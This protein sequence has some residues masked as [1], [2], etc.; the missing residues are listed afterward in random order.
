MKL[1][2]TFQH[3]VIDFLKSLPNMDDAKSRRAFI[4]SVGLDSQLQDQISFDE[5]PAQ[6]LPILVSTLL[7]YGKLEDGQ[8]ALEAVLQSAKDYIGQDRQ[9][10][11]ETLIKEFRAH[12]DKNQNQQEEIIIQPEANERNAQKITK[13]SNLA[14]SR[15]VFISYSYCD[16]D[17]TLKLATDLKNRGLQVWV[18]VLDGIAPGD[19]LG[20]SISRA[21]SKCGIFLPVI[22][23][24]YC[25]SRNCRQELNR[26]YE[27]EKS[28]IPVNI[29]RIPV[30][31]MPLQ[32]AGCSF[33][34]F[35]H[36]DDTASYTKLLNE[37]SSHLAKL[38][39]VNKLIPPDEQIRYLNNIIAEME[40][41]RGIIQYI[42]LASDIKHPWD[43]VD[44]WGYR[45][46]FSISGTLYIENIKGNQIV[47][48]ISEVIKEYGILL[49]LGEP[50]SG[51]STVIR[52]MARDYARDA[53]EKREGTPI[54]FFVRLSE[55][56]GRTDI[57]DFLRSKSNFFYMADDIITLMNRG[58]II[59]FLDGLNEIFDNPR[60]K[61]ISLHEWFQSS[62]R[63]H[64]VVITCRTM[65][66]FG[67]LKEI[68]IATLKPLDSDQINAFA[69]NYLGSAA[70]QFFDRLSNLFE[71]GQ[72][73]AEDPF[74]LLKNP[75][76][77]GA[78]IYLYQYSPTD[79]L[80]GKI[81]DLFYRL[82]NALWERE[83]IR[84][85]HPQSFE[86]VD[87]GLSKL[88]FTMLTNA[89]LSISLKNA[90]KL[91]GSR[92]IL[93]VG[94]SASYITIEAKN[95]SFSHQILHEHFATRYVASLSNEDLYALCQK[96]TDNIGSTYTEWPKV[97]VMAIA[98]R[99][100]MRTFLPTF[101]ETIKLILFESG[102]AKQFWKH[103]KSKA[104]IPSDL[105]NSLMRRFA[106]LGA[107]FPN[108]IKQIKEVAKYTGKKLICRNDAEL[109]LDER[110]LELYYLTNDFN[111]LLHEYNHYFK[112]YGCDTGR[113][114]MFSPPQTEEN[115]KN[116]DR[117]KQETL[118][119]LYAKIIKIG[120]YIE[121][122]IEETDGRELNAIIKIADLSSM[123]K[124]INVYNLQNF[125]GKYGLMPE[126]VT[127]QLGF[128][129]EKYFSFIKL[130]FQG[131]DDVDSE[132]RE[133]VI[134]LLF[135]W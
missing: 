70:T 52:K 9:K 13:P 80:T 125:L 91:V 34:D 93:N 135:I 57:K 113:G 94:A 65:D 46:L 37:L 79:I 17:F 122:H 20:N 48:R 86:S 38:L 6:F 1:P 11:C 51:K 126:L 103:I 129:M 104:D 73:K 97:L 58:K 95:V 29:A 47:K 31:S 2:V 75:Y 124:N 18:D 12:I 96:L 14:M 110:L 118:P 61:E 90:T 76:M 109:I 4:Y 59:G 23:M 133:K 22:S 119:A 112:Y 78:F 74:A 7:N 42:D 33:L 69:R 132:Y 127:Q 44:E 82:V 72:K 98:D 68:P 130:L 128:Q 77:L 56:K 5:P 39:G 92:D 81:S 64:K 84:G 15:Y 121:D 49:I 3:K 106:Y 40:S 55:W 24:D 16:R 62:E 115:Y 88:A 28:I 30:D 99:K 19:D 66:Y 67:Q 87:S 25:N 105:T 53:L 83:R 111:N 36:Y 71:K 54:P 27:L 32:V 114:P 107:Y 35:S 116:R 60:D 89:E 43:I 63:P 101:I 120:K 108:L 8:Y 131:L 41:K 45:M 123:E 21:I 134:N 50:G 26:A 10:Y 85:C 100:D 117:I 102:D